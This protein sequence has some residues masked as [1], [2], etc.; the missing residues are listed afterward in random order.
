MRF[1][2]GPHSYLAFPAAKF[3]YAVAFMCRKKI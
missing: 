2:V 3:M 1:P